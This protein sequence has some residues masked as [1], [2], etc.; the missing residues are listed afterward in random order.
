MKILL[1][2]PPFKT[3]YGRFSRPSRSPA[4][5]KSGTLYYPF[6]L[7]YAAGVLEEAGHWVILLD[8]CAYRYDRKKTYEI[9]KNFKPELIV[10]DTSTP[11]IYNDVEVG[12]ELKTIFPNSFVILVGTHPSALPEETLK[13]NPKIDGIARREYEYTLLELANEL[14]SQGLKRKRSNI[15][16]I[17][18]GIKGLS[19]RIGNKI[20]HNPDRDFLKN[21]D[22]L[23]F[24]SSVYKK[25]LDPKKYFFSAAQYPMVMIITGRGCPF[26]CFFCVYPQVFHGRRY[27]LRSAENVVDEFEYIINN[28]PE[29]KEIGI[30]DDTFTASTKRVVK[31]CELLIERKINRK[32]K[33]WANVRVN[34]DLN[35][36]KLMKEA[37]CRLIIPGFES[38]VQEILNNMNKGITIEQSI[39]FVSDAKK[40]GLIVH[41][42]FMV[43]NPGENR[44][45]MHQTLDFALRLN[46]DTAQFFPMIPYPGTEAYKWAKI[47]SF[48]KSE[49]FQDW[50]TKEGLH[51]TI[52]SFPTLSSKDLVNFC[53]YAR[54]KYYLR[55]K[56]LFYKL[57]Q[58]FFDK[59]EAIRNFLS[60]KN[61]L[62]FLRN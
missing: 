51:N 54:K 23:P 45:T 7:A 47:N 8:S 20:F 39:K 21:L 34:L 33:W 19:Y 60:F 25:H 11:S 3:E 46:I 18:G 1:L 43:G 53:N 58:S 55:P 41:G 17:L 22:D 16:E 10:L 5:T 42:C 31:I 57:K 27:R 62:K 26:K 56:Y 29:V 49:N 35:T 32:V 37:G 28:F 40:A 52:I 4:I 14:E 12:A 9:A 61:L 13:L 38:G 2:N 48:L 30:E 24:V 6:W 15:D 50:L 36:M 44:K 59:N